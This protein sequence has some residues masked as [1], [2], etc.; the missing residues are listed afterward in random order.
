MLLADDFD[1]PNG[2]AFSPDEAILYVND[3]AR[4]HIRAFDVSAEGDVNNSRVLIEMQL[5]GV[6]A[7]D[8][9]KVD[10]EGNIYC[11][12]PG[13]IWVMN[14]DG[15]HLGTIVLPES[16]ANF[17]WGDPDWRTLYVTARTSV[18]RLR[19]NVTGVAVP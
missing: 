9:M 6:G 13:G 14:P 8:G 10:Q 4:R 17:A 5:P 7:P 2:L 11:T 3:S 16:P 18:Y 12:G 1:R 19:L 15:K